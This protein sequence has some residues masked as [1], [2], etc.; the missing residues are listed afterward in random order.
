MKNLNKIKA[1]ALLSLISISAVAMEADKVQSL[2]RRKPVLREWLAHS[3]NNYLAHTVQPKCL[4]SVLEEK[5]LAPA[6]LVLREKGS[7]N[8]ESATIGQGR[9]HI[10]VDS[11]EIELFLEDYQNLP[12]I[13]K[14]VAF[15][16]LEYSEEEYRLRFSRPNESMSFLVTSSKDREHFFSWRNDFFVT[17]RNLVEF[18]TG[19]PFSDSI[20]NIDIPILDCGSYEP[21]LNG[22][23]NG[24]LQ[25]RRS[26]F[27]NEPEFEFE[28]KKFRELISA[29]FAV[30]YQLLSQLFDEKNS[31]SVNKN[32]LETFH[33]YS[34]ALRQFYAA[35]AALLGLT[36]DS[37]AGLSKWRLSAAQSQLEVYRRNFFDAGKLF[38]T[39]SFSISKIGDDY[40]AT[41]VL[42]GQAKKKIE[43]GQFKE[44]SSLE[45]RTIN[46]LMNCGK[47]LT[48]DLTDDDVLIIGPKTDLE[49]YKQRNP[50]MNIIFWEEIP[51]E[52]KQYFP[53]ARLF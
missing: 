51:E 19:K 6:E 42:V 52:M 14:G 40:G 5:R 38:D 33:E 8:F 50:D 41:A 16:R 49:E 47:Y 25:F 11:T 46:S 32:L 13:C 28:I 48:I 3:A 9:S 44:F 2:S 30:S 20:F 29:K 1:L 4:G 35:H 7:V 15:I 10:I 17:F 37:V 18:M 21:M 43:E 53:R 24:A 31:R 22:R 27:I 12:R 45:Y 36:Q 39:I 23:E 34:E 26:K